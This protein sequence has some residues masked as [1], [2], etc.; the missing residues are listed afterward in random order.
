M[1]FKPLVWP[2]F[3]QCDWF[4]AWRGDT[5]EAHAMQRGA[6]TQTE[7]VLVETVGN[8]QAELD[9]FVSSFTSSSLCLSAWPI[10][11]HLNP[12]RARPGWRKSKDSSFVVR[13]ALSTAIGNTPRGP[14][15]QKYERLKPWQKARINLSFFFF[16]IPTLFPNAPRLFFFF[17]RGNTFKYFGWA[18]TLSLSSVTHLGP[19]GSWAER[20]C[21][22]EATV[23]HSWVW[24]CKPMQTV[25]HSSSQLLHSALLHCEALCCFSLQLL[26]WEFFL[27]VF[28]CAWQIISHVISC[29]CSSFFNSSGRWTN[30]RSFWGILVFNLWILSWMKKNITTFISD[31][32]MDVGPFLL[33]AH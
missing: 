5:T 8:W 28:F 27:C 24:S 7:E 19:E 9:C 17:F 16:F 4:E 18:L 22:N 10:D 26:Q 30:V 6:E 32:Q 15:S 11:G 31:I 3:S 13:A 33:G 25:N 21:R 14:H 20:S 2:F 23:W 1:S 29:N 12:G